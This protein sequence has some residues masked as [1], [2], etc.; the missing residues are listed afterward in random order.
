MPLYTS[1]RLYNEVMIY[2]HLTLDFACDGNS[3]AGNHSTIYVIITTV[4]KFALS[5]IV[6][7]F[8]HLQILLSKRFDNYKNS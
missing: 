8:G 6:F 2:L 5:Y 1:M 3:L 7:Q 4:V